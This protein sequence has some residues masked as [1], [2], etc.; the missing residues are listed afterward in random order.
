[1]RQL[2]RNAVICGHC[3]DLVESTDA[4]PKAT[5]GCGRTALEGGLTRQRIRWTLGGKFRDLST[6]KE[7]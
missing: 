6:W 1:M 2:T 3:D 4:F 5:C 7:V